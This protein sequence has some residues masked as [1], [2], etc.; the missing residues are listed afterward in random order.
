M[1]LRKDSD[2]AKDKEKES[3]AHIYELDVPNVPKEMESKSAAKKVSKTAQGTALEYH[4]VR[5]DDSKMH[6][7]TLIATIEKQG[8]QSRLRE[9]LENN[10]KDR[11]FAA[12]GRRRPSL[13]CMAILFLFILTSINT[14]LA[15]AALAIAG[16]LYSR[17]HREMNITQLGMSDF[18]NT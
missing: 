15:T 9:E 1:E 7:S 6:V 16:M 11:R 3:E 18:V 10:L 12:R 8:V 5:N 4:Y 14:I 17:S 13:K 2:K